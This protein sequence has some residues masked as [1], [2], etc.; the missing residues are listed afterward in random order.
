VLRRRLLS[1][2][3]KLHYTRT[4]FCGPALVYMLGF[5]ILEDEGIKFLRMVLSAFCVRWCHISSEQ[6][7]VICHH[8]HIY[9]TNI[10]TIIII[11]IIQFPSINVQPQAT[12]CLIN[13]HDIKLCEHRCDVANLLCKTLVDT[14]SALH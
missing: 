9:N 14:V 8:L 4:S 3:H 6:S 2:S 7:P 11:I 5:Y 10:I 13:T 12:G 1:L